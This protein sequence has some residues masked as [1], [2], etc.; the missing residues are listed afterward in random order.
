MLALA[1]TGLWYKLDP[2]EP[3]GFRK[4]G[5]RESIHKGFIAHVFP[6]HLPLS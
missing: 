1:E 2:R 4:K 3:E 6:T 5:S